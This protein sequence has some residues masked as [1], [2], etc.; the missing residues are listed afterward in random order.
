M[1]Y[2]QRHTIVQ[3]IKQ[4]SYLQRIQIKNYIFFKLKFNNIKVS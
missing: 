4:I 1:V 2:S 3:S